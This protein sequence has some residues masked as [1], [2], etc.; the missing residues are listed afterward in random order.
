MWLQV[1]TCVF[2]LIIPGGN[3]AKSLTDDSTSQ[4]TFCLELS[5]CDGEPQVLCSPLTQ[6]CPLQSWVWF[7]FY[8]YF[9]FHYPLPLMNSTILPTSNKPCSASTCNGATAWQQF[10]LLLWPSRCALDTLLHPWTLG[11]GYD[12]YAHFIDWRMKSQIG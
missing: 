10:F 7:L 8:H 11:G 5:G 3:L 12:N 4:T 9:S 2:A 1:Y 6:S